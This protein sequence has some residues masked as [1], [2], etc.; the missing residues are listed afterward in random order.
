MS[1]YPRSR[2][3]AEAIFGKPGYGDGLIPPAEYENIIR[4]A[5][6]RYPPRTTPF[7]TREFFAV[8]ERFGDSDLE[9]VDTLQ[10]CIDSKLVSMEIIDEMPRARVNP[11]L[12]HTGNTGEDHDELCSIAAAW[13][14]DRGLRFLYAPFQCHYAGGIADVVAEDGS[15]VVECGY[16]KAEKVF[17]ALRDEVDVLLL[18]YPHF[19]VV[20]A[21]YGFLLS[22]KN[23][24]FL[25]FRVKHGG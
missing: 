15:I 14:E 2:E 3:Q 5:T 4:V 11:S 25:A 17:A 20:N 7:T 8:G 21:P 16:T 24:A 1:L 10:W 12:F 13:L 9:A 18:P 19:I 22:T 6:S 23:E